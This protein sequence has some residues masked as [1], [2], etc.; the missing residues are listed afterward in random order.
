MLSEP[1]VASWNG[2]DIVTEGS[3]ISVPLSEHVN[4]LGALLG[5]VVRE[6]H[7]ADT[8]ALI[9]RLRMACRDAFEAGQAADVEDGYDAVADE[10]RHLSLDDLLVLLRA[11]TAFFHLVNK[12]EQLEIIRIN[13]ERAHASRPGR[14]RPESIRNAIE[15]LH[16][17][18]KTLGEVLDLLG[19]LDIQPTLTA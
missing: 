13:R 6:R 17:E 9:E 12:A 1:R 7:G 15:G 4:L 10:L 19:D 18:G 16:G 3:G 8:L 5:H 11:F 2:L 14:L